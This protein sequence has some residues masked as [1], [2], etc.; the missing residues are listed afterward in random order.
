[1]IGECI[2]EACPPRIIRSCHGDPNFANHVSKVRLQLCELSCLLDKSQP[3]LSSSTC[4]HFFISAVERGLTVTSPSIVGAGKVGCPL[5]KSMPISDL[6]SNQSSVQQS[7]TI[8]EAGQTAGRK[9]FLNAEECLHLCC[10]ILNSKFGRG[11]P[12]QH[13]GPQPVGDHSN[14]F[15][16]RS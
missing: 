14:D 4:N 13:R 16:S 2:N 8:P 12:D 1:M 6:T 9:Q 15:S 11:S 7:L 10:D 5:V 3:Y